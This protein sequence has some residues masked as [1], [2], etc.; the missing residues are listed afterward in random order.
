M[1]GWKSAIDRILHKPALPAPRVAVLA[2][3]PCDS[4][5][6]HLSSIAM[7]EGWDLALAADC[8]EAL[9]LLD[10]RRFPVVLCDRDLPDADWRGSLKALSAAGHPPCVILTSAVNDNYLWQ[11]VVQN[12]GYDVVTKPL[13][14]AEVVAAVRR[15]WVFWKAAEA[16]ESRR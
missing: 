12:G 8:P 11:E 1:P 3:T 5:R 4:D 10:M 16:L 2:V 15:A 14:D 6:A 13:H 9:A 7:R